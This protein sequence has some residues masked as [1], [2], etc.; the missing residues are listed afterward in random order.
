MLNKG[1]PMGL[2]IHR[3]AKCRVLSRRELLS[4]LVLGCMG[5]LTLTR[6]SREAPRAHD[7]KVKITPLT[8]LP[9]GQTLFPVERVVLR[10]EGSQV[11]AM[12]LVCTHQH[13]ALNAT[14]G[15]VPASGAPAFSCPCHGA[16]FDRDGKVIS[17]PTTKALPFYPVKID[18]EGMV[19]VDFGTSS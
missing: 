19:V 14:V 12:S 5:S 17:G 15:E 8:D 11:R 18:A 16:L 10:R 7:R 4:K 9:E 2:V 13:C 6:C 1:E 3:V